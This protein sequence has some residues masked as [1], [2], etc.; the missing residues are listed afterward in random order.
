MQT[1]ITY[2]GT[3]NGIQG[4][5]CGFKPKGVKVEEKIT[6]YRPDEGKIFKKGDEEFD[7]VILQ[8]DESIEDYQEVE[9]EL[10]AEEEIPSEEE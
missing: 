6:V 3:L 9:I 7:C 8:E 4:V 2:R 5:W 1:K 10:K